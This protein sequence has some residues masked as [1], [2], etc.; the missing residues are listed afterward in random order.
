MSRYRVIAFL[1]PDLPMN[2]IGLVY[3]RW[4]RSLRYGNDF[5]KMAD[6]DTYYQAYERYIQV[7]LRKPNTLVRL[8][9]LADDEDVVLGFSISRSSTEEHILDYVHVHKDCRKLGIARKLVPNDI[10][11]ITHVTKTGL[12]IWGSKFSHWKFNPF[13]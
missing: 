1:G 12:S 4:M 7:L 8:A 3:S 11:T 2:Y 5:F 13:A 9:V 6:S 10:D